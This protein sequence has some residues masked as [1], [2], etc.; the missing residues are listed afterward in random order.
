[1]LSI[2]PLIS[3]LFALPRPRMGLYFA[4]SAAVVVCFAVGGALAQAT[5][6]TSAQCEVRWIVAVIIGWIPP[7]IG[8]MIALAV[9]RGATWMGARFSL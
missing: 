4:N 8:T 2:S 1:V 7:L 3:L 9:F 6:Q 5:H